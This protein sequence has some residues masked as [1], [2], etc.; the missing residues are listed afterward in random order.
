MATIDG[1]HAYRDRHE[2]SFASGYFRSI[3][4][5]QISSIGLGTYL[6][7][8]TDE[9]DTR[10]EAALTT[11]LESGCNAVDT[12]IN[13][14]HQRSERVVARAIDAAG[15]SRDEVFLS[16]K[17]GFLAF[18]GDRPADPGAYVH[19]EYVEPGL[20]TADDVAAGSHCMT[21]AFLSDQ[22]DRS[23]SNLGCASVDLYYIH[24]PETQLRDRPREAVYDA[25]EEAFVT[26]E[27]QADAGNLDRYG[28]AT[29]DAFR[30]S[31]ENPSHLSVSEVVERAE[32]AAERVDAAATRFAAIQLPF[33]ASMPEAATVESQDVGGERLSALDAIRQHN[34]AAV[35]SASIAQGS[36]A[37]SVPSALTGTVPGEAAVEQA[38]NFAR[39]PP[40]VM[41][42]LVGTTRSEHVTENLRAGAHGTAAAE[43]FDDIV[44]R[45]A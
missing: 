15:V 21:P 6:G 41:T 43:A 2:K 24:N 38:I 20:I 8:P 44:K 32:A 22:L 17:G 12:A 16:T 18:D 31:S 3:D 28:I 29:W 23:L 11:A 10:Y 42:A 1:T 7:D 5:L 19:E 36:L 35:T 33:N 45:L 14:R 26:L 39:S 13:Y 25:L 34:L 30:V 27:R 37:R 40:G 4:D 9:V